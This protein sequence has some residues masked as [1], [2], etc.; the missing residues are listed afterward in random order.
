[1]KTVR[2][3]CLI[4]CAMVVLGSVSPR[5]SFG[6][7]IYAILERVVFEPND[8]APERIQLWGAFIVPNSKAPFQYL[9]AQRG[10]LYF[11]TTAGQEGII[12]NEWADLK[13][14]AGTD[15]AVAFAD[16]WKIPAEARPLEVQVH[17][18]D[19]LAEARSQGRRV[20][21]DPY[22]LGMGIVKLNAQSNPDIVAQLKKALQ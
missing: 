15:Q 3:S 11:K 4:L 22:P 18:T 20:L 19:D 13:K 2:S 5:A 16:Y 17:K 21:P 14:V 6:P 10:Y 8:T 9:P 12:R 7:G 1:M